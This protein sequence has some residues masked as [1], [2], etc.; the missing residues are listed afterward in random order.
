MTDGQ[1]D[2]FANTISRSVC[3]AKTKLE[4]GCWSG[5]F[6]LLPPSHNGKIPLQIPAFGPWSGRTWTD[7]SRQQRQRYN[8]PPPPPCKLTFDLESGVRVTCNV[9][10]LCAN[11]SLPRPLCSWLRPDVRD[12]GQ[13]SDA[14]VSQHHHLMPPPRGQGHNKNTASNLAVCLI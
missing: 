3:I 10:Y 7:I 5:K 12:R 9:G 4:E 8:M 2:G 14:D 1:T 11:F 13:M 6:L